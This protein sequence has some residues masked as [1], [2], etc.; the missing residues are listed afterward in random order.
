MDKEQEVSV[1]QGNEVMARMA[2]LRLDSRG[3]HAEVIGFS[4]GG[5]AAIYGGSGT[6]QFEVVVLKKD[7]ER[8][9]AIL[10]DEEEE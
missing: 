2:L 1:F 5:L 4:L 9:M 8:S 10:N 6:G 3:I 7:A